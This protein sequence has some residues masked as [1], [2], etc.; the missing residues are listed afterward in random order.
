MPR[1][2]ID[3]GYQGTDFHGWAA[4]PQLRTVQGTLEAALHRVAGEPV[5]TVVAGRTDAGVHAR[6]QVVHIDL[7]DQ[8]VK[9]IQ[10]RSQRELGQALRARVNGALGHDAADDL[11]VHD[12]T[13]V[14]D[15][16]DARFAAIW[17]RYSYR[18]ADAVAFHDPLVTASTTVVREAL[19]A[20][21]M[22]QAAGELLGLHDFLPFCKPRPGATTIRTL[23][24][25]GIT[26]SDTGVIV[27][28]LRADAFC[29]HMVRAMV[30]GLINVGRG[31]WS[32]EHPAALI[33]RADAGQPLTA[34][35]VVAPAAGLV[36]EEI[37]YPPPSEW[38]Q[39]IHRARAKRSKDEPGNA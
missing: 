23:L 6:R 14:N 5:L 18:I 38:A 2:R 13:V 20:H 10:G 35:M 39:Q 32:V 28:D 36:L 31:K 15:D 16:F 7:S 34:P 11:V 29:H 4:Q 26:R 17:R 25:L 27:I 8:A 21:R 22:E 9:R 33:A 19:D 3:L 24:D 1:L 37:G 12:A 30:G